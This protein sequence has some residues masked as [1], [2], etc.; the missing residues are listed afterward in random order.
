[1]TL[2]EWKPLLDE[3]A[4]EVAGGASKPRPPFLTTPPHDKAAL[5]TDL[6]ALALQRGWYGYRRITAMLHQ[7]VWIV[8][9]NCRREAIGFHKACGLVVF[10]CC[11]KPSARISVGTV[12]C[13]NQR[14]HVTM[15]YDAR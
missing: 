8:S 12:D 3:A 6:T 13:S 15:T 4:A 1:M 2:I 7:A 9:I 14:R 5:T 10:K 11:N